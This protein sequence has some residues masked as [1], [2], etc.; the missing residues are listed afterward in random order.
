[1][2]SSPTQKD[3]PKPPEPTNVV[4][5]NSKAPPLDSGKSTKICRM[6]TLKHDIRPPRFYELFIETELKGDTALD[7]KNFYNP[8]KMYLN[9]VTRIQ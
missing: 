1:M 4:P 8:T 7:L 5:T 6:W 9:T 3:S 2:R